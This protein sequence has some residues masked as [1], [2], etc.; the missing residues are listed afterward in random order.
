MTAVDIDYQ[1]LILLNAR[2]REEDTRYRVTY[3]DP[4]TACLEPPGTCCCTREREEDALRVIRDYY[5]NKGI[6][7]VFSENGLTFTLT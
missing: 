5:R 2:L 6:R 1:D 3:K 4:A 7:V